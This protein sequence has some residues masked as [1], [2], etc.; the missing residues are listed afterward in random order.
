M[1]GTRRARSVSRDPGTTPAS[2]R[3]DGPSAPRSQ[4]VTRQRSAERAPPSAGPVGT[5][6]RTPTRLPQI[7]LGVCSN[8]RC[9]KSC[10]K[11]FHPGDFEEGTYVH[12][13]FAT[14][15]VLCI[16]TCLSGCNK[17]QGECNF[18]HATL[19]PGVES[20]AAVCA[21][22]YAWRAARLQPAA[23]AAA[24]AP[25]AE[26]AAAPSAPPAAAAAPSAPP[27]A[28]AAPRTS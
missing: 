25:R 7:N 4:S 2:R 28:A 8:E 23:A 13:S 26:F 14:T 16:N 17:A 20:A 18:A 6:T 15:A 22:F 27:A 5:A 21:D 12:G 9:D 3:A 24:A 19:K 1:R 11:R 10:G